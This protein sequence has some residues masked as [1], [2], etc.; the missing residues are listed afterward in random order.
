MNEDR[1]WQLERMMINL[2]DSLMRDPEPIW[3]EIESRDLTSDFLSDVALMGITDENDYKVREFIR[4][5]ARD[6]AIEILDNKGEL[7]DGDEGFLKG[8]EI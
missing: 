7:S 8:V 4:S 1:Y 5:V 2:M 6:V 3:D